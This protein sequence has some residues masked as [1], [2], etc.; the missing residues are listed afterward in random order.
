MDPENMKVG[1]IN[2]NESIKNKFTFI[3]ELPKITEL[4]ISKKNTPSIA[5]RWGGFIL[6]I[7]LFLIFAILNILI[8]LI[9]IV[10][11]I[12]QLVVNGIF[13]GIRIGIS[14]IPAAGPV[15]GTIVDTVGYIISSGLI[16]M[17]AL[18]LTIRLYFIY[19]KSISIPLIQLTGLLIAIKFSLCILSFIGL[20]FFLPKIFSLL[21]NLKDILIITIRTLIPRRIPQIPS[22][23][24][25]FTNNTFI[26]LFS[27]IIFIILVIEIYK[28]L[29]NSLVDNNDD[30]DD[31]DNNDDDN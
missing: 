8:S 22:Y 28:L 5:K 14:F 2:F 19:I 31:D 11:E 26:I 21:K 3:P 16:P 15:I 23:N 18:L 10:V 25:Y 6:K 17:L 12:L 20:N 27:L 1:L 7:A 29:Q 13:F 9:F 4:I 30:G 24:T